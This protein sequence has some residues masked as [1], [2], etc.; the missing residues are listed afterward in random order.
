MYVYNRITYIRKCMIAIALLQLVLQL[1]LSIGSNLNGK[2][3]IIRVYYIFY[4][5]LFTSKSV[6]FLVDPNI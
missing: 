6:K 2:I 4:L 1:A 5:Q 3:N